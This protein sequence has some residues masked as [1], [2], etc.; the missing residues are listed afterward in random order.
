MKMKLLYRGKSPRA[1]K[2]LVTLHE[3]GLME[4]VELVPTASGSTSEL[5]KK[6]PLDQIPTLI[7]ADDVALYDSDVICE[8]LDSLQQTPKLFPSEARTRFQTLR[9][10]ALCN[11]MMDAAI[12]Y[13][14]ESRKPQEKC[15]ADLLVAQRL[16]LTRGLDQLEREAPEWKQTITYGQITSACVL[17]YLDFRFADDNWRK[18]RE[19]LATWYD[20]FSKR[21]SMQTTQL[22]D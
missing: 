19:A 22:K 4:S 2:V 21:A 1:R 9:L 12:L 16:K 6:N 13:V 18:G 10:K 17:G 3:T 7:T 15:D 11:G 5:W 20:I 14:Q 8:Y